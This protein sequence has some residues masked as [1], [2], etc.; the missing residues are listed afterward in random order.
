MLRA[1]TSRSSTSFAWSSARAPPARPY[2][3]CVYLNNDIA[4]IG[5]HA[6]YTDEYLSAINMPRKRELIDKYAFY[7]CDTLTFVRARA[8]SRLKRIEDHAFYS[9]TM[10]AELRLPDCLTYIGPC[11]FVWDRKH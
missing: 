2:L 8:C 4:T 9:C 7:G 11:V 1:S 10:L 5:D 6:F 3:T